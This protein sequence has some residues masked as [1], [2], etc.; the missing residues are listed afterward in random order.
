MGACQ[1]ENPMTFRLSRRESLKLAAAGAAGLFLPGTPLRPFSSAAFQ[2]SSSRK[3]TPLNRFPRAVQEFLV[4]EV[5]KAER[6]ATERKMSLS[7]RE[8]AEAY[9]R[10]VREKIKASFGPFPEKTPLAAKVT[11]TLDRDAYRVEKVIYESRPEFRVTANLYVPRGNG[12][13]PAVLGVCGHSANGKAAA[14]YQSFAQGLARLGFICLLI[15]PIG[16]GE[17]LQYPT[18]A[19]PQKSEHGG[20][21]GEHL[22]GGNQQYL[23]GEFFGTWRAWDAIR[24][25]DYLLS[26]PEVDRRHLGVT[27]NS[28]GGTMTTW[29]C[30]LDERITMAAPG[31][32]VTTFRRNL[33]NELPADTEQCP[34]DAIRQRLDHDDFLAAIAP[35]PVVILSQRYDYF[36]IRGARQAYRR[37]Q[38]LYGQFGAEDKVRMF[39]GPEGHGFS[40]HL[41]EAMYRHFCEASGRPV[42]DHEPELKLETDEDLWCTPRGQV[43]LEGS[44]PLFEFTVKKSAALAE[45]RGEPAGDDL[46][47]AVTDVLRLPA[48]ESKAPSYRILRPFPRRGYPTPHATA[49]AIESEP[50]MFVVTTRLSKEPL[51]AAPPTV[52][53]PAVLYVAHRSADDELRSEPLVRELIEKQPD[54]IIYACDVRGVGETRP[55]VANED[56]FL[57]EYGS[58]Y[59]HAAYALMLGRPYLGMKTHDVL[60]ALDWVADCGHQEI[61]L[62]GRGWGAV[63]AA[64]AALLHESVT[65]VT[66]KNAL[67]S[68]N[69]IATTEDYDWPLASLPPGILVQFD[70]PDVYRALAGKALRQIEPWG[71]QDGMRS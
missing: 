25:I 65:Q 23:V 18:D 7:G 42:P 6:E 14:P 1:K 17:R 55:V 3:L 33:E 36:D 62:A 48:R 22:H 49:Y 34:P 11:G 46:K 2:A 61:H 13:F 56:S 40:V 69:E 64:F 58:N 70:L 53:G 16:Q 59:M 30:G 29:I 20:G 37:L 60:R 57:I 63:P 32:F 19:N 47:A 52:K 8:Q 27:G 39:V 67:S 45:K 21:V 31:C 26:H 66:L 44:K 12:P 28:G 68:Y 10:E 38:H 41:R 9:S 50:G 54:A 24:G 71:P 43:A 15:D 5:R 4:R 51:Y 35:R